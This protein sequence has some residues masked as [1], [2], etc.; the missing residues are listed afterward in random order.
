MKCLGCG[1][2]DDLALGYCY[3]CAHNGERRLACRTVCQHM[4]KGITHAFKRQWWYARLDFK[5]AFQ[6]L[7]RIGDY[8]RGGYF[9]WQ[10]HKWR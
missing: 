8:K 6:R 10:G 3:D 4:A 7:L 2:D 9:D 1:K 5:L